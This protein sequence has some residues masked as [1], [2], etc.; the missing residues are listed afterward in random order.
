[1][2]EI[3]EI[4]M[5]IKRAGMLPLFY[6]PEKEICIEVTKTL[7]T[8]GV[9]IVEFTARGDKALENLEA[10]AAERYRVMPDLLLAVG[11]IRTVGQA[12]QFMAAGADFLIS[13][14]FDEGI[15]TYAKEQQVLWIPGCMT[16]TEI[17]TANRAGC[18]LI[19][20][21]PGNVLG[22]SYVESILPLFP[23]L[24][25]IVTGGV[26]TSEQN[27]AAWLNA[28]VAGVGLGSKLI[29]SH[30]LNAKDFL[31][32]RKE[33]ETVLEIMKRLKT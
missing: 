9:R 25:I 14:V 1:M 24:E 16:P 3:Q 11:T 19:K 28:G 2:K 7:Y 13:P 18:R 12:R 23:G 27:I 8:A 4:E 20:L 30:L 6:H 31:T 21:F 32:L 5:E 22:P 33:T 26:D 29:S 10:L 15:H 17:H